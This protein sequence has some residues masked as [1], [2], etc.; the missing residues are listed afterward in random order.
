MDNQF[1]P[2]PISLAYKMKDKFQKSSYSEC[3]LEPS[4]GRGDLLKIY[5]NQDR[6][7]DVIE[8]DPTNLAI[9]KDK[10]YNIVGHD[11]LSFQGMKHYHK[12]IM[13]P[14]FNKGVDHVLKAWDIARNTEIV[15]LVNAQ[16]IKNPNSTKR[17]YLLNLIEEFGSVEFVQ[18]E[19]ISPD[20]K[21]KTN[22]ECAI[23]YLRK[24]TNL[25]D[26]E[27]IQ[28]LKVKIVEDFDEEPEI[29]RQDL[30]IPNSTIDNAIKVFNCAVKSIKIELTT[31]KQLKAQSDYY[32]NLLKSELFDYDLEEKKENIYDY[33][34]EFNQRYNE[35]K[36]QAWGHVLQ[37]TEVGKTL[38]SGVK[39]TLRNKFEDIIQLEFTHDNIYGFLMGITHQRSELNSEMICETFDKITRYDSRNL[40][41]YRGWKSN[42]KHRTAGF[43]V[44]MSRIILPLRND[45]GLFTARPSHRDIEF[46]RDFDLC[47]AFLDDHKNIDDVFGIADAFKYES[48][49]W[50]KLKHAQ[51]VETEYFDVRY[52][53]GVGTIH[54]FPRNKKLIERFNLFVGKIRNWI[55]SDFDDMSET[56]RKHY[57]NSE[58]FS[59]GIEKKIKQKKISQWSLNYEEGVLDELIEDQLNEEG[60]TSEKLLSNDLLKIEKYN[61]N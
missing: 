57:E 41:Y 33:E 31:T 53:I 37:K 34:E 51:R 42:D 21:R 28:N 20:T 19:F 61:L 45:G 46:M 8:I 36:K 11:F 2:T 15:A 27:F 13:N 24:K 12:I 35:L 59:K 49:T 7:I 9:L 56:W 38:S 40:T 50:D 54:L 26:L 14:P 18:N 39:E 4:A 3:I 25:N 32:K 22:V 23:I 1:Y 16:T 60:T 52:Y 5:K 58:K 6:K 29:K 43:K 47:F 44:R 48:E 30:A 10:K 55:P 17:Q